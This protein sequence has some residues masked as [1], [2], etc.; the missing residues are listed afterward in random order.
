MNYLAL[1]GRFC[2]III[3]FQTFNV[4]WVKQNVFFSNLSCPTTETVLFPILTFWN[5]ETSQSGL[6]ELTIMSILK[7]SWKVILKT[8][9]ERI[10]KPGMITVSS[11]YTETAM[12]IFR[13]PFMLNGRLPMNGKNSI[14]RVLDLMEINK[15]PFYFWTTHH[16]ELPSR[17][18]TLN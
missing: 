7:P 13:C 6:I 3:R 12:E 8:I 18:T 5:F 11:S 15:I 17:I 4:V 2:P 1:L 9:M 16:A 14:F 10:W